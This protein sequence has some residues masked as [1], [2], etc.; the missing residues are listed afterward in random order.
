MLGL[1]VGWSRIG[2]GVVGWRVRPDNRLGPAM[3]FT[4]FAWF[5]SFLTDAHQP[6]LFTVG[7]AVQAFYLVGFGYLILSFPS[8]RLNTLTERMVIWSAIAL[9][10]VV[11]LAA[12]WF[13]DSKAVLCDGCP[14]NVL[15][16]VRNDALANGFAQLTR[17]GGAVLALVAFALLVNRWRAASLPLRRNV[18]PVLAGARSPRSAAI[19]SPRHSV[20][21]QAWRRP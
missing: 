16:I 20:A 6:L 7:T 3:V 14:R 13:S 11:Q 4:G 1:L 12:L 5:A 19:S 10:A 21:S 9:A 17:V 15:E 8:G 2:S 18:A